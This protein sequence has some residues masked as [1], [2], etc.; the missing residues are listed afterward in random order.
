MSSGDDADEDDEAPARYTMNS[1]NSLLKA[2]AL[3]KDVAVNDTALTLAAL[4][5]AHFWTQI[6]EKGVN[7]E[8]KDGGYFYTFSMKHF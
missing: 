1:G 2:A 8:R 4:S 7:I 5:L 3:S 6:L